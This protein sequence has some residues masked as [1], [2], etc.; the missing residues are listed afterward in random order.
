MFVQFLD[1][2]ECSN[3]PC[4]NG[5]TCV[6][7]KGSYRCD[8]KSGYTGS[9]CETGEQA[10]QLSKLNVMGGYSDLFNVTMEIYHEKFTLGNVC[11]MQSVKCSFPW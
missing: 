4:K 5:A 7:L 2:N 9:K 1:R 11:H 8:C 6:N 3:N 10:L